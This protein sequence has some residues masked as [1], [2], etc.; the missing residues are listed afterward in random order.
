MRKTIG[1]A[2]GL[3]S[4]DDDVLTLVFQPGALARDTEIEV[5][6]SDAP[7]P[8]FGPAYRVRPD[9]TLMVDVEVTYRRV[10][11]SNPNA[12]T[13]GAI[14]LDDY[15]EEMG[16]WQPLTRLALNSEQQSVI[17]SDDEL[18]LYYGLLEDASAPPLP[19]DDGND[20]QPPGDSG[21]TGTATSAGPGDATATDDGETTMS[22]DP[23]TGGGDGP[24]DDGPPPGTTTTMGQESSG[25]ESTD[26]GM[27][28]PICGDGMPQVGELCLVAGGDYAAG[29]DP[30][31]V[32]IGDFDGGA[33]DVVTLDS[34]LLEVG[35]VPGNGDGTLAAPAGGTAVGAAPLEMQVGDFNGDG[36]LDVVVLD[37][38]ADSLGLLAG[39]GAGT[40]GAQMLTGA[41]T[42]IVDL[43]TARFDGGAVDDIGVLNATDGTVQMM[44]GGGG[45]LVAGGFAAVGGGIDMVVGAADLN[46]DGNQDIIGVGGAGYHAWAADGT[47]AGFLGE[48]TNMLGGVGDFVELAMADIDGDGNPDLAALDVTTNSMVIGIA[49]GG[50]ADFNFGAVP[51]VGVGTNPSDLVLMDLDGDGDLEAVV[52]NAGSNDVIV[53]GWTGAAYVE[54]YSFATGTAPSGVAAGDLSGDGIPDIVVSNQGSDSVTVVL[55]DP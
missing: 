17:A 47:G 4:S 20:D 18:S 12:A 27:V 6:P 1:P 41:G 13:I 21:G 51:P 40:L 11:P 39:D 28:M 32:G 30:I 14:R 45:G 33:L 37:T 9:V 23:T 54:A 34:G 49:T 36:A 50:P 55:S 25:G 2:G 16:Y 31:D 46:S 10:L 22:V 24:T 19:S 29:L 48:V 7:P 5:F 52:C 42:G 15:S 43:V 44:L 38:A 26:D 35:L 8:I 3:I 53:F